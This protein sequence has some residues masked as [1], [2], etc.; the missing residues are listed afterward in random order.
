M[1][2]A[3][4]LDRRGLSALLATVAVLRRAVESGPDS[5]A[6][7]VEDEAEYGRS[8]GGARNDEG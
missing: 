2:E 5:P 3:R 6:D 1:R 8:D 4:L 7:Q